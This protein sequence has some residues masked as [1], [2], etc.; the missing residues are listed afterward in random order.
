LYN[1]HPDSISLVSSCLPPE[2]VIRLI[3]AGA[4]F[5]AVVIADDVP[6]E[7]QQRFDGRVSGPAG[8]PRLER[9]SLSN[10]GVEAVSRIHTSLRAGRIGQRFDFAAG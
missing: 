6:A 2:E 8:A 4:T 7:L 1:D 10:A 5:D 3:D 9:L